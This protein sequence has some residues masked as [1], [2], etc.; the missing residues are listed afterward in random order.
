MATIPEVKTKISGDPRGFQ[1]AIKTAQG[2][3][4]QLG[5]DL[6]KVQSLA[7]KALSFAGIGGAASVAGLVA[8]ASNL[9]QVSKEV[10]FLAQVS[11][12]SVEEFQK[13]AFGA[14][15]VGIEQE[16]LADIFKDTQ[17]K[18]G[19]FLQTGGGPLA[20]FFKDIAPRVGVTAAQFRSLSGPQA[21]QLYVSS[22]EKANL[23]QSQFTFFLEAIASDSARL[24]PLL[25]N[26][27]AG[28]REAGD[29]A[30]RLG[31]IL[32][33]ELVVK[34]LEF[35]KSLERLR[36]LSKGVA[37]DLGTVLIPAL[38]D[39]ATEYLDA[40]TA[41]LGF[42][43]ALVGIGL[44]N[45]LKTAEQ[46]IAS[47]TSEIEKLQD[48]ASGGQLGSSPEEVSG[49]DTKRLETLIKLRRFYELQSRAS[50]KGEV[51]ANAAK[52]SA[53][54]KAEANL[55]AG[56]K[57]LKDLQAKQTRAANEEE[58]KGVERLKTALQSAWKA[59]IDGAAK[60]REDAKALLTEAAEARTAGADAAIDRRSRSQRPAPKDESEARLQA[61]QKSR[62]ASLQAEKARSE[63]NFAASGAVIAAFQGRLA[64]S[65]RLSDQALKT[66]ER[67]TKLSE[68]ITNDNDAAK[69]L[70]QI[71]VIKEDALKAQAQVKE[72]EA[73]SLEETATKQNEQITKAEE[74]IKVLKAEL[75]KPVTIT[76]EI[77]AAQANI[78]SLKAEL[79]KLQ[80]KTI[81][82]TVN[83][84]SPGKTIT[85]LDTGESFVLPSVNPQ[86]FAS[87]GYTGPGGKFKPAGIV[88]AGEYVLRQE[89][90]KQ[91]GMRSLLDNLNMKGIS[92]LAQRGYANGGLVSSAP[93]P[94]NLQW[95]DGTTSR[96]S[97]DRAVADEIQ[98]TF[99]R[100]SLTRGR[101]T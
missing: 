70:E 39:L 16:K 91:R 33:E 26:N 28:F 78:Q 41:G 3:L 61:A 8:A 45:P 43:E 58:L 66:A 75:E 49:A 100:A 12:V 79:D 47:L 68:G 65:K 5:T 14:R 73:V 30:E 31:G 44:S 23:S 24:L 94:I 92:A 101:R 76:T 21:L 7:G 86:G 40:R 35:E 60:A 97:A 89:V 20:D 90:V 27:G 4:K 72:K 53:I 98:R 80:N 6:T 1:R 55:A 22:L 34:S 15:T 56:V 52:N 9:S 10:T 82:V 50:E 81:T 77:A 36:T 54:S 13:L 84:A 96:V 17:D 83:T 64:E 2:S 32:S 69:L 18:I 88:H 59:S 63:A 48:Q 19:E 11:N 95:P 51:D 29:E 71:G 57:N 42:F 74:R 85:N 37:I 67:A 38:N 99:R 46:Q 93:T 87:G 25:R 62:D